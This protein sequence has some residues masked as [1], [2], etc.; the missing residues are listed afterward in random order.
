[1]VEPPLEPGLPRRPSFAASAAITYGSQIVAAVLSL[2]NVLIVSRTLGPS[3]RGQIAF[4]TA[5]AFLSAN[6]AT[7]GVQEAMANIAGA[8]PERRRALAGNA[9]VFSI[10]FGAAAAGIVVL[11]VAV[12]PAIGGDAD[13]HLRWL[14][15]AL[16]PFLI[17]EIYLR[18]LVQADYGFTVSNAA[19]LIPPVLNVLANAAFALVGVLS[20]RTAVVTWLAGQVLASTLLAVYVLRRLAGF[21]RPDLALARRSLAF[22][23]KSHGG[24]IMLLGNYRLDQWILGAISGDRELGLYSVAV[25]WAEALFYLP[26]ALAAVQRPDLV[27]ASREEAG[28][29]GAFVFRTS[30]L[31]TL[32]LAVGLVVAAPA[33]CVWTF[34]EEF[35]GSIDDLR[36]L[37]F[38]G[39]GIVALK[40]LGSAL[41]AQARPLLA[42]AA[43]GVGF[44]ST[45]TLDALLIPGHGGLGAAL[46]SSISYSLGGIA[47]ALIFC[48]T[49][50]TP[51]TELVPRGTEPLQLWRYLRRRDRPVAGAE[52][53]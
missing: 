9:L 37:A 38:G 2:A 5:I 48:R 32:V 15:L 8:E 11:L 18:F 17:L 51:L 22:G 45:V 36:V 40:L 14:V 16:I 30:A 23:T 19:W 53:T 34:G 25:A 13:P 10:L 6:L 29:Q 43:I 41:T 35:R 1:M 47:V 26:T 44:L 27:R 33:L 7:L 3:G 12:F 4:L 49:L 28:R 52:R 42:T 24:R 20:V 21:G 50:R 46:A 31:F 39:V